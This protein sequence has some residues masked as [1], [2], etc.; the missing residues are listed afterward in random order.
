MGDGFGGSVASAGDV[1]GDGFADL[2]VGAALADPGGRPNA[3]T[4]IVYLGGSGGL[5]MTPHRVLE[6]ASMGD[7]FGTSVASA[8]RVH[9]ARPRRASHS[10]LVAI[11]H[12]FA[13]A[14]S[15]ANRDHTSP[16]NSCPLTP[17]F[18]TLAP[19]L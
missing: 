17:Q 19:P 14:G 8:G 12:S 7:R 5:S 3:G 11:R 4:A 15:R 18:A 10:R 13:P 1:N 16:P 9:R 2:V 6:G